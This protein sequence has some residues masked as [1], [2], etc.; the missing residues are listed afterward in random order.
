MGGQCLGQ[1]GDG[2]AQVAFA[3][4]VVFEAGR[5]ATPA[6]IAALLAVTLLPFSLVGPFA[7]VLIDRWSRRRVLVVV[8]VARAG[9]TL[10]AVAT[11]VAGSEV[12]AFAGVLLLLS[13]SRFVMAAKGASLPRTVPHRD[14]VTA[15]AISSV[16]GLAAVFIGAVSG[17][18]FV[19]WSAEVGFVAASAL[20]LGAA[21]TFR[22]LPDVG[23]G[24]KQ[25]PLLARLRSALAD[26]AE[27]LRAVR[28]PEIGRPLGAVWLHRLLLGAGFVLVVLVADS[29]FHMEISGYGLALAATGVAAFAGSAAAPV[30]A[31]RWPPVAL[32]PAAF[33]PPAVAAYI[34][35]L[36]PGLGVLVAGLAVTALSF[37]VLKVLVD[38]LVGGASPDAVRGRVFSVYDVLYNVAFVVAGLVMVPLW[39]PSRIRP[40]LWWLAAAFAGGWLLCARMWRV[41][42]FARH[43]PGPRPKRRWRWR[44]AALAC[45]A[46][47][48]VAFPVAG[49]WWAAWF[50]L[51]PVLLLLRAAPT[52][53]EAGV[54]GWWAGSGYLLAAEYWLAPVA[55]PA[56]LLVVLGLGLLWLPWGW[57]A[58]RMLT[59]RPSA[60]TSLLATAV[61][62][63]IWVAGEAV[64]SWQALGGPWQ[65]LGASQ[66]NQPL[67]LA[68]AALGGVWL[69]GF[70]IGMTNV[71]LVAAA[72]NGRRAVAMGLA[73]VAVL[74]AAVGPVWAATRPAPAAAGTVPVGVVQAGVMDKPSERYAVQARLT[75]RLRGRHPVLVVWG[76]SSLGL[77][78]ATHSR[79]RTRLAAL[80]RRLDT[81]L[82][83][84]VDA[85]APDGSIRKTSVLITPH[86]VAGRY[87]KTRLVPFGE[88]IP[89]RPLLGW[90][91]HVSKAAAQDRTPGD[92]PVV[93]RADGL[94]FGPL[95]CFEST[96]PDMARHEV[97]LGARLIVYQTASTTFQG[98]WAQPQHASLAAVRAVETGRPVVQVAL[99]GTSAVFDATGR[100]LLWV[101]AGQRRAA[102]VRIQPTAG[103]T[104]YDVA[105]DWVLALAFGL[106]GSAAV[107]ASF[108][109]AHTQPTEVTRRR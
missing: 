107:G 48:V 26:V 52:P 60:R 108:A 1:A 62:P 47:P 45:G 90:V 15:N 46:L 88:Y 51:V 72:T 101:P 38:A 34:S 42:P 7:G 11:A 63:A 59:G 54:R 31:R 27:G 95:V 92:G 104:P 71:A 93:L 73:A 61:L 2:L 76:E 22:R 16:A 33:I 4:F 41:W 78:L 50:C 79:A 58:H 74:A 30:L 57:A 10:A 91:A 94:P 87:V 96:F 56:L 36:A 69:T 64:R 28:R 29:R 66:W 102:V 75:E 65:L 81:D 109:T 32:L 21:A 43:A 24:S 13:A 8:S 70:L 82:L 18:G 17:T 40:L 44:A 105:G 55:G 5:G 9:L 39:D 67:T 25:K 12:G 103:W 86:G 97:A 19:G 49:W 83:V 6:R 37:Q 80:S 35:G 98:T 85:Q 106:V 68:S 20:Y 99:T 100:L 53:R 3:Q 23:G 14:L 89:L 77:D 84:N